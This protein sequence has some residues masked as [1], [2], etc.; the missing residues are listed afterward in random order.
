MFSLLN[1]RRDRVTHLNIASLHITSSKTQRKELSILL[2]SYFHE[3]LEPL[4][5]N[6][7]KF[8]IAKE[9]LGFVIQYAYI[10]KLLC[11][12]AFTW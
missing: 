8:F 7:K 12:A 1:Y 11:D 3:L 4:K 9:V 5:A 6:I 2:S 10:S